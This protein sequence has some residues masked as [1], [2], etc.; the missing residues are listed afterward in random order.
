MSQ[1]KSKKEDQEQ[2]QYDAAKRDKQTCQF[3]SVVIPY[4]TAPGSSGECP[5]CVGTLSDD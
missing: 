2:E 4:G 3:C 5:A 1:E